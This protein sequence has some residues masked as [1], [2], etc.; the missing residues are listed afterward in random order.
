MIFERFLDGVTTYVDVDAQ[1]IRPPARR[2][3]IFLG[4]KTLQFFSRPTNLLTDYLLNSY[5][6]ITYKY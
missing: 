4:E 3:H 5:D 6:Y 1:V 2:L